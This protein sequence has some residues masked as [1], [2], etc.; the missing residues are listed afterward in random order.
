MTN[1]N[2]GKI[3]GWNGGDCPVHH[4]SVVQVWLRCGERDTD[5]ARSYNWTHGDVEDIVAF[6]VLK[7]YKEAK[8][9]WANEYVSGYSYYESEVEAQSY[10]SPSA[11]RVAVKFKEVI[12]EDEV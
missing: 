4:K 9:M 10:A 7:E 11:I 3:H 8:Y 6:K 2:D 1:Y 5:E 12:E